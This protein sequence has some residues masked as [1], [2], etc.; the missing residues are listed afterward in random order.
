MRA[1][2]TQGPVPASEAELFARARAL[3]GMTLG[4]LA[5][6]AGLSALPDPARSKGIAGQLLECALG[7]TAASRAEPDFPALGIE[8]KTI[9]VLP[10][11][12][13]KE[14]TFVCVAQLERLASDEWATCLVRRKLSRVL[15]V[16]IEAKGSGPAEQRRLGRPVLWS[17]TEADD[18][19]LRADWESLAGLIAQGRTE[20]ITAHFGAVLQVR[21]KGANAAAR[22]RTIDGEGDWHLAAPKGFYLRTHFT[23][24]IIQG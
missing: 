14:S 2:L 24:R 12:S 8:L 19:A 11:G 1:P 21:P 13:P 18:A 10:D 6:R 15:W 3:S 20:E 9:P 17:P 22:I 4:E 5:A 16:P 7:A 23:G